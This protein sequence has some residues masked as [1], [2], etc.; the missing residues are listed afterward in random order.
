M[1]VEVN[2]LLLKYFPCIIA[3]DYTMQ[4]W[5]LAHMEWIWDAYSRVA[6]NTE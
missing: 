4:S 1:L 6:K 2:N 3:Y 5:A